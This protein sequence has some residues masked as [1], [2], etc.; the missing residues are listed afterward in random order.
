IGVLRRRRHSKGLT[1]WTPSGDG[2]VAW[3]VDRH[4]WRHAAGRARN[5]TPDRPARRYLCIGG[6]CRCDGGRGGPRAAHFADCGDY[7]RRRALLRAALRGDPLRLAP[8]GGSAPA[9]V[10]A[11]CGAEGAR[12]PAT[13]LTT[14]MIRSSVLEHRPRDHPGVREGGFL[15]T[16]HAPVLRAKRRGRLGGDPIEEIGEE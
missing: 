13:I 4:R 10:S 8:A 6:A 15:E 2:G 9:T 16:V 14:S 7:R 1:A 5:G 12:R 11:G 3:H